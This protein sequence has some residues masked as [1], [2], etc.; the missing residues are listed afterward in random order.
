[1]F[2]MPSA[3]SRAQQDAAAQARASLGQITS[4][5]DITTLLE[6]R[7]R[8]LKVIT[9]LPQ[10]ALIPARA[11][12]R[13]AVSK[14]FELVLDAVSTSVHIELK[15]LVGEQISVQL[16]QADGTYRG[17]HGYVVQAF[18]LGSDGGLAL[19][20]LVMAPWTAMAALRSDVHMFQ[21]RTA[22]CILEE[23]FSGHPQAHFRFDLSG[24]PCTRRLCTQYRESDFDFAC[25]LMAEEGW[26]FH[27]EHLQGEA[28]A[29]ADEHGHARHVMVITDRHAARA[30]L[31]SLRYTSQHPTSKEWGQ[32]D[33]IQA[34]SGA[35][36]LAANAVTRA[37]WDYR[38]L[39][40]T[41]ASTTSSL[42]LGDLPTLEDYDGSGAY[43]L[44]DTAMADERA[45][46]ALAALELE[47][48]HLEGQ[49]SVR[50]LRAGAS[51]GLV[52]HPLYGANSSAFDDRGPRLAS[53]R[54]PDNAFTVL[55]VEHHAA[56]N[57]GEN[58]AGPGAALP[59]HPVVA[60]IA[61]GT[62]KNH[63]HCVPASAAVVP[64]HRPRPTA[65]GAQ[66]ARV[67]GL[68]GEALTTDRDHR[69]RI[70]FPWQRGECSNGG[71]LHDSDGQAAP[72]SSASGDER[73]GTW[74]RVTETAAGANWGSEFTPR[75]GSEVLVQFVEG[76]INRPL[77]VAQLFNAADRPP[78]VAGE[79]SGTNHSGV[80]SGVH[81]Q[82]LD[83]SGFNQ[84]V[85]DDA[86]SQLRM[87]LMA[88]YTLGELALGHLIHQSA[89]SA[90][91]GAW[92]GAGFEAGTQG[93][94]S[95]RATRG[96]LLSTNARPGSYSSARSTQMDSTEALAQL[97]AACDLAQRLGDAAAPAGSLPLSAFN[98]DQ[99]VT[100][101]LCSLDP[102]REGYLTPSG[103][104]QATKLDAERQPS[105]ERV[106]GYSRSA[107]VVDSAS[108]L[109]EAC[110][111]DLMHFAGSD[112]ARVAQGSLHDSAANTVAHVSGESTSVYSHAGLLQFKAANGPV[113]LR[114]H[115]DQ[116]QILADQSVTFTSANA[117]IRIQ[118]N[119]NIELIAGDS[120]IVL[121]GGNIIFTTPGQFEAKGSAHAFLGA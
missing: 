95:F 26:S 73:S 44:T 40:G 38:A 3:G 112:V 14:P 51:F 100:P 36:Q 22:R 89:T 30:W 54:R 35:R 107:L 42:G 78:F 16:L 60:S 113:V 68:Q 53:R 13:E 77:I 83:G 88:S 6:Q 111:A 52:D 91:R 29:S 18:D 7:G 21:D 59:G 109:V 57:L 34:F 66:V 17:W 120:G 49:G 76:D 67:V 50:Q 74:V 79:G 63:F 119:Q 10:L 71:G 5:V 20:R 8:L 98:F 58:L 86:T 64:R 106:E 69:V 61:G 99:S 37:S 39:G 4:Q 27:F 105:G 62:Y 43:R 116:L 47:V 24:E 23:L 32:H 108:A 33:A 84:W 121:E 117:E 28:A 31:G 46:L 9:A 11:V 82:G 70:Q 48:K 1:M 110:D 25:R 2:A 97:G 92:R 65:L 75:I 55:A 87:R 94:A 118:A 96:L 45:G 90:E 103:G 104:Q 41:A 115:N 81:S 101:L 72:C 12:M 85:L 80:I 15:A 19:Y 93:W 56:N 114:A 102:E